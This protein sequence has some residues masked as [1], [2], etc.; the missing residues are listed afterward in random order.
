MKRRHAILWCRWLCSVDLPTEH[1]AVLLDLDPT[2]VDSHL[3]APR[4][5]STVITIPDGRGGMSQRP[6]LAGTATKVKKLAELGYGPDRIAPIL[7]LDHR[8]VVDFLK[9]V[10]PD[11]CKLRLV[12]PRSP[13]EQ[14]RL[15]ANRRRRA[16]AA[17]A[18]AE[19]AA[20]AERDSRLDDDGQLPVRYHAPPPAVDQVAELLPVPEVVAPAPERWV[21][22]TSP[23]G[24]RPKL[25]AEQERDVI[26]KRAEG[27]PVWEL[28]HEY[29]VSRNTITAICAGRSRVKAHEPS[30]ETP[31]PAPPPAVELEPRAEHRRRAFRVPKGKKY[32]A[33]RSGSLYDDD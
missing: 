17:E 9:R 7:V 10:N 4:Y 30:V 31:C 21:G 6:I 16:K 26:A 11:R 23:H 18:A 8:R 32:R 14:R 2:E 3:A 24:G 1:I 15:E 13:A 27:W 25:T 20:W 33:P 12:K 28:A 29:E 5:A 22:P 19:R